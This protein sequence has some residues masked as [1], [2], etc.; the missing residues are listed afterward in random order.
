MIHSLKKSVL[1]RCEIGMVE[2][3]AEEEEEEEKKKGKFRALIGAP[4]PTQ[5]PLVVEEGDRQRV[6][7]RG[8]LGEAN[9]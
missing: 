5:L 3:E 9:I 7:R 4:S 1:F 2:K 6:Q 8:K